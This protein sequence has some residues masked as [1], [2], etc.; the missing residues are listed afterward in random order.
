MDALQGYVVLQG[1][2]IFIS[3]RLVQAQRYITALTGV[4]IGRPA[5]MTDIEKALGKISNARNKLL[6]GKAVPV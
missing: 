1:Q 6:S 3:V 5:R 2:K 4:P